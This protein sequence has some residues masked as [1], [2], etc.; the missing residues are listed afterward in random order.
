MQAIVIIVSTVVVAIGVTTGIVAIMRVEF[1]WLHPLPQ[2]SFSA[3][4]IIQ[5]I[6]FQSNI[7]IKFSVYQGAGWGGFS[8]TVA[9]SFRLPKKVI[10]RQSLSRPCLGPAPLILLT[11]LYL[12][13]LIFTRSNLDH[14]QPGSW[15][16]TW[17]G[18]A[19]KHVL[20]LAV[21][22]DGTGNMAE[23]PYFSVL[24]NSYN[25]L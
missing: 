15:V 19:Q 8:L 9:C 2:D 11:G 25:E 13:P 16:G 22:S 17:A 6:S 14:W 24:Y 1:R 4:V 23:G 5:A 18:N 12:L 21:W 20:Q 10:F 7:L 3:R